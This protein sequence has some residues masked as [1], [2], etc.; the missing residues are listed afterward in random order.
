[1]RILRT[2]VAPSTARMAFCASKLTGCSPI[3]AQVI[4][5][6]LVLDKAIFLQKFAHQIERR[7]LV[8][9]GL[10][11]NFENFT[12]GVHGTPEIDQVAIDLEM[13]SLRCEM[14]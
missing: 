9:P 14:M 11:E 12:L 8:S 7:P 1:M 5:D 13:T 6:E 3:R 10:D 2:I 4:R